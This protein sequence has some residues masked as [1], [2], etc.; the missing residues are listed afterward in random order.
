MDLYTNHLHRRKQAGYSLIELMVVLT[1]VATLAAI[2][3]TIYAEYTLRAHVSGGIRLA[4]PVKFA[5]AEYFSRHH[6]FPDSNV[7]ADIAEPGAYSDRDVKSITIDTVP[8]TGTIVIAFNAR[9]VVAEG[10]S[11]LLVPLRYHRT[12][13]WQC[14]SKTLIRELLP[15]ACRD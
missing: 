12:V 14:T 11:V 13:L 15:S 3:A 1:I 10:D 8:A 6:E 7:T 9:G 2:A 5:V 4:A